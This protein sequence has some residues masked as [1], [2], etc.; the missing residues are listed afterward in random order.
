MQDAETNWQFDIFA[1]AELTP[2]HT[3]SA[4]AFH[5]WTQGGWFRDFPID[6]P[7]FCKFIRKIEDGYVADNPYHNRYPIQ[8]DVL[9]ICHKSVLTF[10]LGALLYQNVML[11]KL[12]CICLPFVVICAVPG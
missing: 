9:L 3:L 4:L 2:G 7:R 8:M 10:L 12:H 6:V 5:Y 1:L 11:K